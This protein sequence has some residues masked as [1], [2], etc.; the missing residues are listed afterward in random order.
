MTKIY[1]ILGA[2]AGAVLAIFIAFG[3]GAESASNKIAAKTGK[4]AKETS[5]K[6]TDEII[7]GNK[8]QEE[9]KHAK[10]DPA[11]KRNILK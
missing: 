6:V 11:R 3:K 8:K 5:D 4:K 9:I 10:R 1:A 7:K 2:I